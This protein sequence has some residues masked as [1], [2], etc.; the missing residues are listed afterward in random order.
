MDR[1]LF[2]RKVPLFAELPPQDLQPIAAIAEEQAFTDGDAIVRQGDPGDA[3]HIIVD[4]D[5]SVVVDD[6]RGAKTVARRSSGDVVGE[7]ALITNE[8]RIATLIAH[9]RVRV[10]SIGRA[11]FEA[12][13]RER[14]ETALAVMRQLCSR[15]AEVAPTDSG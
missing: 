6:E 1:V 3:M 14:P 7:M 12:I 9:D 13:L 4:G 15:L 5:V 10:L 2:L 8:P 11:Q